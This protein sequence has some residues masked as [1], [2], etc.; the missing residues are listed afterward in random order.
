MYTY[1]DRSN[2]KT[3]SS[4]LENTTV[5]SIF[6]SSAAEVDDIFTSFGELYNLYTESFAGLEEQLTKSIQR[7]DWQKL[8]NAKKA[9]KQIAQTVDKRQNKISAQLYTQGVV[10]LIGNSESILRSMFTTLVLDNFRK[11][12]VD[13]S[14]SIHFTL[15]DVITAENDTQL[16]YLFLKKL[17]ENGNPAERLN[18]Q[19]MKQLQ[20]ILKGYF[21]I[22]IEDE[23]LIKPHKY[24][25]VRHIVVHNQSFIDEQFLKNLKAANID[26]S[27]YRLGEKIQIN[28]D[29]YKECFAHLLVL[30]DQID[31]EIE[32]LKLDHIVH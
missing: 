10:L 31:N 18:F 9:F 19:N 15:Q 12:K 17:E 26:T 11:L 22:E 32:K 13:K 24:T 21:G 7:T 30:F 6:E 5:K 3:A 20:G 4:F 29:E 16:G 14:K 25:Q 8:S 2:D 23:Y 28:Q 1:N 27:T